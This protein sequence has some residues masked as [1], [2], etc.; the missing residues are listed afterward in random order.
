MKIATKITWAF[1]SL[2]ALVIATGIIGFRSNA[3]LSD[4]VTFLSGPAWDTADGAMECTIEVRRQMYHTARVLMGRADADDLDAIADAR[5]AVEAH[6]A[7]M[8]SAGLLAD[9]TVAAF[10]TQYASYDAAL[11][12]LLEAHRALRRSHDAFETHATYFVTLGEALEAIGDGAIEELE[13]DPTRSVTWESDIEALWDAADGGMESSIGYLSQL[14]H[15]DRI[16][17]GNATA[18]SRARLDESLS[19]HREAMNAMLA[20]GRFDGPSPDPE[21]GTGSLADLYRAAFAKHE[22][23]MRAYL[24]DDDEL[25]GANALYER[26]GHALAALMVRVEEEAD[27]CV[28]A[29]TTEIA[30]VRSTA[31]ALTIGAMITGGLLSL[32]AGALTIRSLVRPIR[33]MTDRMRDIAEGDGDLTRRLDDS[34]RDEL[35]ELGRWFNLFVEKLQRIIREMST[36][37]QTLASASTELSATAMELAGGAER[38][39]NQS[40]AV[41][42]G[43]SEMS[44]RLATM[45]SSSEEMATNANTV[46][47]AMEEMTTSIT[48]VASNAERAAKVADRASQLAQKSNHDVSRLDTAAAA[49]GKVIE[50]IEDIAEQT[51]LLAL[52]ATIEAARAGE[53]GKGFA[54][55]ANEVKALATQTAEATEDIRQRIEGI[56]GSTQGAVGSIGEIRAVIDEVNGVSRTIAAAVEEQS[57]TTNEILRSITETATAAQS[58]SA[59]VT[60]SASAAREI[61]QNISGIDQASR[62]TSQGAAQTQAAGTE[63]SRLSEHMH[64]L[65]GQFK[66]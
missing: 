5:T 26:E 3:T 50:T 6:V 25:D 40:T 36:N 19:F 13:D 10:E 37:A 33:S 16:I 15:V 30:E 57:A 48:E 12:Q 4:A 61:T 60:E 23:L 43:A 17:S 49:I 65:V 66:V 53:A 59:S 8:I 9:E 7:D 54:V 51:N 41:A 34:S 47:A 52:N 24:A 1:T 35:G 14:F 42:T 29:S 21:L 22:T 2:C 32:I 18:S 58:V 38:T 62:E 56:Q 45:A 55:V 27:A 11:E 63:L 44:M 28:V 64:A 31:R 20:T 46:A 39:T